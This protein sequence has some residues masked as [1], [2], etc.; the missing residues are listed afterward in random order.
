MKFLT[1]KSGKELKVGVLDEENGVL[2]VVLAAKKL[3]KTELPDTLREIIAAGPSA[4]S[5]AKKA[6]KAAQAK[7]KGMFTPLKKVKIAT[8]LPG[9][10]KN[11]F[12]VGRNYK[13][14]IEEMAAKRGGPV[15]YPKMPEFFSKPPTTIVGHEDK[16]E[17]HAKYTDELD[18]E[19]ELGLVI[20][21]K[22]RN[23]SEANALKHVWGYTVVND[24][25]ARDAQRNH[26]QFFKGKSYDSHC[27]IG[28]YIVTADE[29][30]KPDGHRL[31]LKVNGKIR[32]DSTTSD[33]YFGV[34]RII[35][36]LSGA[37]TLEP[38]D[39]VATGTPSGVAAGMP[40]PEFLQVGDIVE[41]E[42][43]GIGV[44]RNKIVD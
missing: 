41:A 29:F 6:L 26:G 24:V 37:L 20:G 34:P 39:I 33:L 23:I 11:V 21:K 5:T 10:T 40:K 38:G 4:L 14:H 31:T 22:G 30:G 12:C 13:L 32:Q 17:R 36:S 44:L 15:N 43:E 25:T 28:P 18:Y 8:P 19:V 7:P 3:L 16:V 1:Y 35:E 9:A 2:D 27:P 42:V